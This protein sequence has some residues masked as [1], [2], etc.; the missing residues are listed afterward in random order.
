MSIRVN[1]VSSDCFM[2]SRGTHQGCPLFP[3]LFA[4]AI[5][6][7]AATIHSGLNI[8]GV[9]VGRTE[10]M[11]SLY[12]DNIVLYIMNPYESISWRSLGGFQVFV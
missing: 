9:C 1:G 10:Y 5:E 4:L 8:K 11:L 2:L 7:L 3:V 12:A 6:P